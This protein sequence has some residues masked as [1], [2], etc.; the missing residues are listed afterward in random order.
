MASN[1]K[2]RIGKI[3]FI[4]GL[5]QEGEPISNRLLKERY[6]NEVFVNELKQV[7]LVEF[8][9]RMMAISSTQ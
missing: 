7:I 5:Y 4:I 1:R 8:L 9:Q 6:F 3:C 2:Y